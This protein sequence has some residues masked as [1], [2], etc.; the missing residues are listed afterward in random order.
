MAAGDTP[1]NAG[2]EVLTSPLTTDEPARSARYD[3]KEVSRA[4]AVIWINLGCVVAWI[5]INGVAGWLV[6]NLAPVGVAAAGFAMAVVWT[7]ALRQISSGRMAQGVA[8]YTVSGL[9][10]LLAMGLFLPEL[11]LLF[12]FATFIFLAFGLSYM[13][14]RASMQVVALTLV[15]ALVLLLTSVALRRASGVPDELFRWIN[16]V[17]M[18]MA[19]SIDATMFI[20]LRRTLEAR[21]ERLVLAER[22]A[23]QMQRR[24]AQQERL[25]SLGKLAGGVAHDFNNLLA[26]ILNYC[27][28][29]AEAVEG[30]PEV[31]EDVEQVRSA[32]QRAAAL[33]RQ[34]LIF[35]RRDLVRG[36]VVDIND[37]VRDTESLLRTAVG[38]HIELR[39]SLAADLPV[40]RV[41]TSRIEQVL[42]NLSVN[43]RDAMPDGGALLIA[44]SEQHFSDKDNDGST[45]GPGH[46]VCLSVSDTG[47]GFSDEASKHVFEPFFTTKPAGRGTG[48]GL[49]TVHSI[50]KEA[51]GHASVY[52]EP[53]VGTT[54]RVYLPVVE[55]QA[56]AP[57]PPPSPTQLEGDGRMVLLVEDEPQLRQITARMLER[58]KYRVVA[59]ESPQAALNFL[60]SDAA[61]ALLLTD[62]VMP[63]MSGPQLAQRAVQL[64]PGL[65]IL[66]MSGFPRDLWERGDID[67]NLLLV[68]KPFDAEQLLRKI[69]A[70]LSGSAEK[71]GVPI[72]AS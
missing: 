49:A 37:V 28:F 44:T 14:G 16:L 18:L 55:G 3:P 20:M 12:V 70:A 59:P 67:P 53:G 8:T 36:D 32:A 66:Y 45:P 69:S 72:P 54:V 9:L 7:W 1:R 33:T 34:L 11:A 15:V 19:L 5:V 52:S 40:T 47:S 61:I 51:G 60:E 38:E 71:Q 48:L 29:I 46:H 57:A 10:L 31:V 68:E 35:G 25:E 22:E 2:A 50:A 64:R 43:A 41:D 30:R 23:T 56:A 21:A 24:I 4:R 26:I 58:H 17:G 6:H 63:G 13:S 27:G 62:V 39:T 42:L 65:P